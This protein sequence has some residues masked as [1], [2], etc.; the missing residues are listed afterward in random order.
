MMLMKAVKI[1][2]QD[3]SRCYKLQISGDGAAI[4]GIP[5]GAGLET[6]LTLRQKQRQAHS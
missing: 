4:S 5:N 3:A 1:Q 6:L 2:L